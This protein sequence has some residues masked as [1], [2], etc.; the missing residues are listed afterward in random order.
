[1]CAC[2]Y[3]KAC[4]GVCVCIRIGQQSYKR[5]GLVRSRGDQTTRFSWL[6]RRYWDFRVTWDDELALARTHYWRICWWLCWYLLC[7]TGI[8]MNFGWS[9]LVCRWYLTASSAVCMEI[10]CGSGRGTRWIFF[11]VLKIGSKVMNHSI[12][13]NTVC[14]CFVISWMGAILI[15]FMILCWV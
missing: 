2:L 11:S 5:A 15:L 14:P 8:L 10:R 9:G 1:M 6:L 12:N 13:L 4:T 3:K 7:K